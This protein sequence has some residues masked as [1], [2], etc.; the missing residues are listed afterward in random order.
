MGVELGIGLVAGFFDKID[1]HGG[2]SVGN[3]T[4]TQN[5]S[6]SGVT[7][8][9]NGS[10]NSGI[11][12]KSA[13][14]LLQ[15]NFNKEENNVRFFGDWYSNQ[16]GGTD[17]VQMSTIGN[18]NNINATNYLASNQYNLTLTMFGFSGNHKFDDGKSLLSSGL[19]FSVWSSKQTANETDKPSGSTTST[20]YAAEND[21][22]ITSV[23]WNIGLESQLADWLVF[24]AGIEKFIFDNTQT[25]YTIADP[26]APTTTV[27]TTGDSSDPLNGVMFSTG[28]G[29]DID[30]WKLDLVASAGSLETSL[31]NLQPGN[32][33]FFDNHSGT[34]TGPI[35]TIVEAELSHPL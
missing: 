25:K 23:N 8:I 10:N 28:F 26:P 12:T 33:I 1:L 5:F 11:N 35:V 7:T 30:K 31:Q 14:V 27:T 18:F 19:L 17:Q 20:N 9:N 22:N 2:Y 32:G 34:G 16:F 3:Y 21:V 6:N 15:H 13:G 24:R 29:V 4:D